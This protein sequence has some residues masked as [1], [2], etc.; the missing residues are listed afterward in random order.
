MS[1]LRILFFLPLLCLAACNGRKPTTTV[2][3]IDTSL[4]I[5]P[6]ADSAALGAVRA[7][8]QQ[9]GRGDRLIL[10]PVTG[11]AQNDTG[12]RILRLDAPTVRQ[13]YDASLRGFRDKAKEK[14][15]TWAAAHGADRSR[16][17]LLGSLDAARQE[18]ALLP[19]SAKPR[20]LIV[21][22]FIEDDGE[23]RFASD[24]A[25]RSIARARALADQLRAE[26]GFALNSVPVCLGRLESLDFAALS[27]QRQESIDAFWETY[28]ADGGRTPEIEIDGLGMLGVAN[29]P[30]LTSFSS[31]SR[32]P[33]ETP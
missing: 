25:L 15:A 4:S 11:D 22:D 33:K 18:L 27:P 8:I 31:K 2:E 5:S 7:Q 1:R 3:L 16:T 13:A 9:M 19:K 20:L 14:F 17:D 24:P 23:F 10:I 32:S 29:G 28:L 21:S 30:C 6:R 12:G 26:Q